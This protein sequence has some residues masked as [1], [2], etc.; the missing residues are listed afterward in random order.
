M[1]PIPT[2]QPDSSVAARPRLPAPETWPDTPEV[3]GSLATARPRS[4]TALPIDLIAY[5]V[6]RRAPRSI[7]IAAIH[8]SAIAIA[9]ISTRVGGASVTPPRR[10]P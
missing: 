6:P 9:A 1:T 3:A 7:A 2:H 5:D 4:T 8:A 10:Q